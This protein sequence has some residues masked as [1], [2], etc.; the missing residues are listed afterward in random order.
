MNH[1]DATILRTALNLGI[2][3]EMAFA[4][5]WD[6]Y[7]A[8]EGLQK[9]IVSPP[10][11]ITHG[12][13]QDTGTSSKH[14]AKKNR[15]KRKAKKKTFG[16]IVE[17]PEALP[18]RDPTD[19]DVD[20]MAPRSSSGCRSVS[21][22]HKSTERVVSGSS[23]TTETGESQISEGA[24]LSTL[25]AEVYS[26][27]SATSTKVSEDP[28]EKLQH[29]KSPMQPIEKFIVP[30][31]SQNTVEEDRLERLTESP[32]ASNARVRVT[33]ETR[34][35][36]SNE[37]EAT[38]SDGSEASQTQTHDD[39]DLQSP[40]V[41]AQLPSQILSS[42]SKASK[43]YGKKAKETETRGNKVA[44]E[45]TTVGKSI[46][47]NN[48]SGTL[49]ESRKLPL[50]LNTRS[51]TKKDE[52]QVLSSR[53]AITESD[54]PEV[55][56][57]PSCAKDTWAKIAATIKPVVKPI[58]NQRNP[59]LSSGNASNS[60][61]T[62]DANT[63]SVPA[64]DLQQF[65]HLGASLISKPPHQFTSPGLES[66][67]KS[68]SSITNYHP[69]VLKDAPLEPTRLVS[70]S[71][72]IS[73][74]SAPRAQPACEVKWDVLSNVA[75]DNKV[76]EDQ[77][78]SEN[79][80]RNRQH[81]SSQPVRGRHLRDPKSANQIDSTALSDTGLFE[82]KNQLSSLPS[83]QSLEE[84]REE[85]REQRAHA[86]R[87][88][89]RSISI[90][91]AAT[92]RRRAS[93]QTPSSKASSEAPTSPAGELTPCSETIVEDSLEC[94]DSADSITF[95]EHIQ[96]SNQDGV[97][98]GIQAVSET[99]CQT[100]YSTDTPA[101]STSF[102]RYE[103]GQN[104]FATQSVPLPPRTIKP[105]DSS[106]HESEMRT[107]QLMFL[108]E[109][110]LGIHGTHLEQFTPGTSGSFE[111]P[112]NQQIDSAVELGKSVPFLSRN[113]VIDSKQQPPQ[114][115]LF[116]HDNVKVPYPTEETIM[117]LRADL[118]RHHAN[119]TTRLDELITA[120]RTHQE[121]TQL[122]KDYHEIHRPR[123]DELDPS[124]LLASEGSPRREEYTYAPWSAETPWRYLAADESIE[125]C[126]FPVHVKAFRSPP[127]MRPS[128]NEEK[129][130][131]VLGGHYDAPAII[132]HA[133]SGTEVPS[134][135]FEPS[136]NAFMIWPAKTPQFELRGNQTHPDYL[137]PEKL[138]EY[139]A[140]EIM[141]YDVW[142][143]DR[144]TFRCMLPTCH[145]SVSDHDTTTVV[146]L[147]CG[148]HTQIRYCSREHQLQDLDEH[149]NECGL[150]G[151]MI[152]VHFHI[153]HDS[154]PLRYQDA[155]PSICDIHGIETYEKARQR[156][157]ALW[158]GG[159]Y[160]LFQEPK[161]KHLVISFLNPGALLIGPLVPTALSSS[162]PLMSRTLIAATLGPRVERLLNLAFIDS[163][164]QTG[165]MRY[166]YQLLRLGLRQQLGSKRAA[167]LEPILLAQVK[168]EF[169][170]DPQKCGAV[171]PVPQDRS[172]I[173]HRRRRSLAKRTF[174][175]VHNETAIPP[176]DPCECTW[177]G[178]S[179][180]ESS[181]GRL[182]NNQ[183]LA[184]RRHLD[185]KVGIL[186]RG[187]GLHKH[188]ERV[189][190]S[191]WLL[192]VWHR[193]HPTVR[194]WRERQ[195]GAGF[196]GTRTEKF[197]GTVPV[198]GRG[199]DGWACWGPFGGWSENVWE[200]KSR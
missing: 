28:Q 25:E 126:T 128:E 103:T 164:V 170:F 41:E 93:S 123:Y 121:A 76:S 194:D 12:H 85:R 23:S 86:K 58:R 53:A 78:L 94:E 89:K 104:M 30:L 169:N 167:A 146:C 9:S 195:Y 122:T 161:V 87:T 80:A 179:A 107:Q 111:M 18:E 84:A 54:D 33:I 71:Q 118:L 4:L 144:S 65:P 157:Y 7:S 1:G 22:G 19:T 16:N 184:H 172:H 105:L 135:K 63:L 120:H 27:A 112:A 68:Y 101:N 119:S 150:S 154:F 6:T 181:F 62:S 116:E 141:D 127:T 129:I 193:Q 143:A 142:R 74:P 178:E 13:M 199:W 110:G 186:F 190:A 21:H 40:V 115:L 132:M 44:S 147:G 176:E 168:A 196:P 75:T 136:I 106:S 82:A 192:R 50:T 138:C 38:P 109:P 81:K 113:E 130:R 134:V 42:K 91:R 191:S 34:S 155:A 100:P 67:Q 60:S 200:S 70:Q 64:F 37:G 114:Q 140:V 174:R 77:S 185:A 156:L 59:S 83:P 197:E 139:Q 49:P 98:S 137:P 187:S 11:L 188:V 95:H 51:T 26:K 5:T 69:E 133:N 175:L 108:G 151:Y 90:I 183:C 8:D 171:E 14:E 61:N 2:V 57:S 73:G 56:A 163:S 102:E 48:S 180:V 96:S 125:T 43:H 29:A 92:E 99:Y 20:R 66:F 17:G 45:D 47:Q 165:A 145:Q 36:Q 97:S 159:C 39:M 177:A 124:S 198:R 3:R 149:W 72:P 15:K 31:L 162:A 35:N 10:N 55:A 166:L 79:Q 182:C 189:E 52:V 148:P 46:K 158:N 152:K 173:F 24:Y 153:D 131:E 88:R 160:T 32:V 117:T